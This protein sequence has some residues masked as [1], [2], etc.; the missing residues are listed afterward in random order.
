MH[1]LNY[2]YCLPATLYTI[3]YYSEPNSVVPMTREEVW[4]EVN[5]AGCGHGS[6]DKHSIF[7]PEY[8]GYRVLQLQLFNN[9]NQ[10]FIMYL[11]I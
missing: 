2:I 5:P 1:E 9:G 8:E 6:M 10:T 11:V 4:S 7:L 3:V